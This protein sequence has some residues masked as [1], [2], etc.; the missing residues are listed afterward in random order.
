[1]RS[2][3]LDGSKNRQAPGRKPLPATVPSATAP[4][5]G[6]PRTAWARQKA[7]ARLRPGPPKTR[8]IDHSRPSR[9]SLEVVHTRHGL[10]PAARAARVTTCR[11]RHT[12]TEAGVVASTRPIECRP[13]RQHHALSHGAARPHLPAPDY[14]AASS[15]P[16]VYPT[17]A[18][19]D[20]PYHMLVLAVSPSATLPGSPR[21]D[22][23]RASVRHTRV[24][25]TPSA[26]LPGESG[27]P[28]RGPAMNRLCVVGA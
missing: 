18:C 5:Q 23:G 14:P 17:A 21:P 20:L 6:A 2:G 12:D 19:G 24:R 11:L 22:A 27:P 13:R 26:A 15:Q 25:D 28:P 4:G 3:R 10:P 9:P 7:M 1:V 8:G 16:C